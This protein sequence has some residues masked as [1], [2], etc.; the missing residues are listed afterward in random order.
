MSDILV[1]F[2]RGGEP[3]E[4]S[5]VQNMLEANPHQ[6]YDGVKVWIEGSIALAHQHFWI[7]PEELD[8]EQPVADV[9]GRFMI[10]A[11]A[12][13]DN[14]QE[15]SAALKVEAGRSRRL[16]DATLILL[17]YQTWG[18]E[19]P[20]Y[21]LGD[22][23]FAIWDA[24][25]QQF[26]VA[27]DAL[28]GRN[29]FYYL[30]QKHLLVASAISQFLAHPVVEPRI[31]EG[32]VAEYLEGL[33]V[34]QEESFYEDIFYLPPAHAMLVSASSMRRWRY[35][36]IDPDTQLRY[37]HDQ[38]YTEHFLELFTEAVRCRLR[39]AY[40]VGIALS[41]GLDSTAVAAVAARVL[42]Q[43]VPHQT[44][45][46]S[47]SYVFDELVSCDER[48]FVQPLID[49][50]NIDATY[51]SGD[52][53]WPL[54]DLP[55]WPMTRD[56]INHDP[57]SWLPVA[58]MEAASHSGCR[59]ILSGIFGDQLF[60]GGQYWATEMIRQRRL[61]PLMHT[62]WSS[63]SRF[64]LLGYV[65]RYNLHPLIPKAPKRILS[66]V[67]RSEWHNPGLHPQLIERTCLRQRRLAGRPRTGWRAERWAR[68][69][70]LTKSIEPQGLAVAKQQFGRYGLQRTDPFFDRRLVEY[71]MAVPADQ[72][73]LPGWNKVL[74]RRAMIGLVPEPVGKRRDKTSFVPL[75]EKG[76]LFHERNEVETLFNDPQIVRR[77]FV[78]PDWL[79]QELDA[80]GKWSENGYFLWLFLSLEL[81]LNRYW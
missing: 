53:K 10:T 49:Q 52:D 26:F 8:E 72:L 62:L 64:R 37:K 31:N 28:G 3:V 13:I 25:Q 24:S 11:D 63:R 4:P 56:F 41:G 15:L 50:Y 43:T 69:R 78:K 12:R 16:S 48:A 66:G 19:C 22:F 9:T 39:T 81:W 7:T 30:D 34:N 45:L 2:N 76:L 1:V 42:P 65:L 35:W 33:W 21:L 18:V 75:L 40:P 36:D 80:G 17:A 29:I 61:R 32:K 73:G 54:R 74:L 68:Y 46:K 58:L 59:L 20:R 23:A 70:S 71:F 67:R 27:R 77:Q 38:D 51:I 47:F 57:Y 5:V 44:H 14:R 6:T 79:R 55:S 60:L